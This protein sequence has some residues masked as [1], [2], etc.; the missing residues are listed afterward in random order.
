MSDREADE[1]APLDDPD[2]FEARFPPEAFEPIAQ[3][4]NVAPTPKNLATLTR[5]LIPHLERGFSG[6]VV[7]KRTISGR[8]KELRGLRDALAL[9]SRASHRLPSVASARTLGDLDNDED[10]K[11][12]AALQRVYHRVDKQLHE[13]E[14]TPARRGPK[15]KTAFRNFTPDLVWLYERMT[16]G[17]A[18]KPYWLGDSRSYGSDFYRFAVAVWK[19]LRERLPELK[20]A[21]PD[22]EGALAQELQDH[23]PNGDT[24]TG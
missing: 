17:E 8:R 14:A 2:A 11:F 20:D 5:W 21:L 1:K 24:T 23:W 4:L 18:K 19:C 22:S 16:E 12:V 3:A 9:V 13:L 10:E 7:K 6:I 15:P